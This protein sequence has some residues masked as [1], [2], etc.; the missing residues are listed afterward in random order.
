M[1]VIFFRL[2]APGLIHVVYTGVIMY[3]CIMNEKKGKN[4]YEGSNFIPL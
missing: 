2:L 1:V 4:F 3:N